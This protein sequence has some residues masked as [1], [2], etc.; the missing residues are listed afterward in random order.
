M[1]MYMMEIASRYDGA[2]PIILFHHYLLTCTDGL[3]S[4]LFPTSVMLKTAS[5]LVYFIAFEAFT[6]VG[7]FMYRI[8]P[9]SKVTSKIILAGMVMFGG[10]HPIQVSWIGSAI[11]G[12]FLGGRTGWDC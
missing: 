3:M 12:S 4:L 6:F 7:L 9:N 8:F 10:T 11:F 5:I 2:R 1:M